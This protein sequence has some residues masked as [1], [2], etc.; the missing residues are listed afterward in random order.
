M[1]DFSK[2]DLQALPLHVL[3]TILA[4]KPPDKQSNTDLSRILAS[5]LNN[6]LPGALPRP[7]E[8]KEIET[9]AKSAREWAQKNPVETM[10]ALLARSPYAL[11]RL[12]INA[13][14]RLPRDMERL[15]QEA[16]KNNPE[17]DRKCWVDYCAHFSI[18]PSDH[19]R[20]FM[21]ALFEDKGDPRSRQR[22]NSESNKRYLEKDRK[23]RKRLENL[24]ESLLEK[25]DIG[26]DDTVET[27]LRTMKNNH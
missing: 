8:D 27:L 1:N 25:G 21:E 19:N 2:E 5:R 16:C 14:S 18:V 22:I 13:G 11:A 4:G 23:A 17:R 20:I 12:A 10:A 9:F 3:S 24:L 7:I 26:P 6:R 15:L